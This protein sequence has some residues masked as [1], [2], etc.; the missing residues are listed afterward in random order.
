MD[1]SMPVDGVYVFRIEDAAGE[2]RIVSGSVV[3]QEV[4]LARDPRRLGVAVRR[5]VAELR[6]G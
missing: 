4:G 6:C 1:A 2:V 5:A 3:P